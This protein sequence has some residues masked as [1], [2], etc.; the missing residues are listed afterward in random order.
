MKLYEEY[1]ENNIEVCNDLNKRTKNE[2]IKDF[3][4][5]SI[6]FKEKNLTLIHSFKYTNSIAKT[7]GCKSGMLY[8]YDCKVIF[9]KR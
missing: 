5:I 2:I 1:F 6:A 7:C 8:Y 4:K 9:L 3:G